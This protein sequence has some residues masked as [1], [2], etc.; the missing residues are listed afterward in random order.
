MKRFSSL[1]F[2]RGVAIVL[3]IVLHSISDCLDI[4]TLVGRINSVPLAN[5]IALVVLPFLGGLAGLFLLVS[6]ISNMISMQKQLIR[7]R[8]AGMLALRQIMMGFLI[9]IFAAMSEAFIGYHGGLGGIA[10]RLDQPLYVNWDTV[11]TRWGTFEAIHTVAWC[12]IINGIVQ[13][14]LSIGK[15]RDKPRTQMLIYAALAAL[16]IGLTAPVWI[17]ISK[18]YPGFPWGKTTA[19]FDQF[20]PHLFKDPFIEVIK[21]FFYGL[22]AAPM[23]P[24]FPYL[25]VSFIGS[26]IGIALAQPKKALFKGFMKTMLLVAVAMF[27]IGAVGTTLLIVNILGVNFD[28][29]IDVYRLISFHRHWAPDYPAISGASGNVMGDYFT[30]FSYLWQFL[31]TNGWSL[32]ATL[33]MLYAVEFRGKGKQFAEKTKFIRRFGFI[34]FTNYNQQYIYP[35]VNFIIPSLFFGTG[36]VA[37]WLN[38]ATSTGPTVQWL[39]LSGGWWQS[40]LA[41]YGKTLWFGILV[42]IIITFL[43]YHTLMR[44]WEK[45]NYRG[46]IEWIIATIGYYIV[47]VKKAESLQAKKWY[48]KG[49]LAV[50]QAF[51]NAEWINIVEETEEYHREK[52]DSRIAMIFAIAAFCV[53]L[54]IPFTVG[55]LF[56]TLKTFKTEG[57]NKKNVVALVLCIIGTVFTLIFTAAILIFNLDMFGIAL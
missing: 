5:L 43:I 30:W 39:S 54:F 1:D 7:G 6:A 35:F 33:S 18:I 48:E 36:A 9:Y 52:R 45:V 10:R 42:Q 16:V 21:G 41:P 44:V 26:I 49:D 2:M 28:D 12:V 51:Y 4:N 40:G 20:Q 57:K 3:M 31:V 38:N 56:V 24:L 46:S 22:W 19:G 11:F 29:A 53:P 37:T 27:L 15:L 32:M 8:S 50:E 34:A 23:E 14:L 47:P 55:W 25:A 13:A 17:G